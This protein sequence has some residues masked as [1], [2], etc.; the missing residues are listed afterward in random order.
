MSAMDSRF[1][2]NTQI[3]G[4]GPLTL[5]IRNAANVPPKRLACLD[6]RRPWRAGGAAPPVFDEA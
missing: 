6:S 4:S 5:Q 3:R 2:I 1:I